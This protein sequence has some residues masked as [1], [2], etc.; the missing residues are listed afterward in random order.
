MAT[1]ESLRRIDDHPVYA[2]AYS[3]D[4]GFS[5]YLRTGV[6]R[7]PPLS[8]Q[9]ST[10]RLRWG[11]SCFAALAGEG[12]KWLGRN[13]DWTNRASL[14]LF[15]DSP[16][17]YASVSVVDPAMLGYSAV[18]DLDDW[19]DRERLLAAPYFSL[20]G[21]NEKG[22]AI[23]MMA[24]P[25]AQAP[26]DAG[27]VTIGELQ[28]I[29]LV[30]DYAE[31]VDDAVR[32][33]ERV[34]VRMEQPPIHYLIADRNGRSAAVEFVDGSMRVIPNATSWQVATNFILWGSEALTDPDLAACGRYR[35]LS[36]ELQLVSGQITAGDAQRLLEKVS[37]V[38]TGGGTM[39]SAIYDLRQG[40]LRFAP[41]RK[42]DAWKTFRVP[43]FPKG[44]A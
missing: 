29:R 42:F 21:M 8:G 13:F 31:N 39:W 15:T 30:L 38:F 18:P 3:G 12:G 41:G 36:R 43:S 16:D 22:M 25:Q 19:E 44:D 20:D 6:L 28:V 9:T 14:V 35:L 26:R 34:N 11:C 33:I 10:E 2:M 37:Q 1:L 32:R 23:G 27:K 5:E 40:E 4:Y 7:Y 24:V 17:G